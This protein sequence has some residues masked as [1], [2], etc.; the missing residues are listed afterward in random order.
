MAG[1]RREGFRAPRPRV[2]ATDHAPLPPRPS[3]ATRR[4]RLVL[5][6]RDGPQRRGRG[7]HAAVAGVAANQGGH[8]V[9]GASACADPGPPATRAQ[10]PV[11]PPPLT[12]WGGRGRGGW[13][14]GPSRERDG[15]AGCWTGRA[16][17]VGERGLDALSTSTPRAAMRPLSSNAA[18]P[19][20]PGRAA[21]AP[22]GRRGAAAAAAAPDGAPP[23]APPP[24]AV[25]GAGSWWA[26]ARNARQR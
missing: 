1:R 12:S 9:D 26:A 7:L 14:C 17:G 16:R 24:P 5:R 3:T 21:P 2:A 13:G 15:R 19:G 8:R 20:V 11:P 22:A 4:R 25:V 18:R 6:H 23:Q 10:N